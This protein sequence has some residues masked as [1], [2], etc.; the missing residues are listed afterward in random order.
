MDQFAE[1][2]R[3]EAS[4]NQQDPSKLFIGGLSCD[5][6]KR[7]LFEYLSQFGKII[8]FTIKINPY[9]GLTRR[10]GFVLFKDS[11]SVEKVLQVNEHKLDGK[12]IQLKRAKPMES[13]LPL[14]KVFV[15]GLNRRMPE[16]KI[17]EYF[18]TFGEIENIEL[19]VCPTTNERRAFAFITYTNEKPVRKLLETR[20]HQIGSGWCEIKIALP[21]EYTR[22]YQQRDFLRT[23][24]ECMW[25][26]REGKW[27]VA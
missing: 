17:R 18:G 11:A 21:K 23:K 13:K 15:G 6:S 3:I 25:N 8:D 20:H 14:K 10:F 4:R 7:D 9:T 16:E 5:I 24:A 22:L 12:K 27:V 19:P 1:G 26:I 2:F